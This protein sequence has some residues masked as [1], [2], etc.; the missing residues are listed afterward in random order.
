MVGGQG[1]PGLRHRAGDVEAD[2]GRGRVRHEV[3]PRPARWVPGR[4]R[5]SRSRSRAHGGSPWRSLARL[6]P[7]RAE[8]DAGGGLET[9]VPPV[10]VA[11]RRPLRERRVAAGASRSADQAHVGQP[12][13]REPEDRRNTRSCERGRRPCRARG[14]LPR[15]S[16]LDPSRDGGRRG[17]GDARL[18]AV[19]RG[20]GRLGRRVRHVT[21]PELA[22]AWLRQGRQTHQGRAHVC[23]LVHPAP[24][25]HGG[26]PPRPRIDGDRA[27]IGTGA[28]A[29]ARHARA[30]RQGGSSPARSASSRKNR[31]T[32][33]SGRSTPTIRATSGG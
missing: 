31:L 8:A 19:A 10:P 9:R 15:A 6:M 2:P 4:Q 21:R 25:Q 32:S 17:C 33:P 5:A 7:R 20:A 1:S 26:A 22:G 12:R 14:P 18:R 11:S 13:A 3:E 16:R 23:A 30:A 29:R 27:S 28:G 24:R